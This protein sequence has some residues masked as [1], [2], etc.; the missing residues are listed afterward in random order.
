[1]LGRA[2]RGI[3]GAER[4]K[5]AGYWRRQCDEELN[6]VYSCPTFYDDG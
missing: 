2:L 3:F 5:V 1:V 6:D 4:D